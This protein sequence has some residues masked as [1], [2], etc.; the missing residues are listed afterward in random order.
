MAEE[1]SRISERG[2]KV[3]RVLLAVI[4]VLVLSLVLFMSS[5]VLRIERQL[6]LISTEMRLSHTHTTARLDT[7][8]EALLPY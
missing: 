4:C 8:H 2:D 7:L 1:K 5:A 6:E 3:T